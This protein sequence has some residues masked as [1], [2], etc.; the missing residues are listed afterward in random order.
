MADQPAPCATGPVP[1][2][3]VPRRLC[4]RL[5]QLRARVAQASPTTRALL[6]S[7]GAGVVFSL[8]NALLRLLAQQLHPLQAQ[9][10][11]YFF[12]LVVML[13]LVWRAGVLAYRPR[14]I[15]GQFLRG[16]V[17]AAGL[18]LWFTAL[19]RIALADMTAIGFT[20]PLFIMIGAWLFLAE[21]MRW[22]R[23]LATGIGFV[24]ML[25][26][27]APAVVG[28]GVQAG[29]WHLVMLASAPVFAASFLLTKAL[30]RTERTEVIV[31]WQAL[32]VTLFSIP[33]AWPVWQW[34]SA[35][36]WLGFALAGLLGSMGHYAL[37]R[38]YH[39]ADI[40][41]TQTVKFLDLVWAALLGLALL[42]EVPSASTLAGGAIISLATLWLVRRESR[43]V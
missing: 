13:P 7:A 19:P 39:E 17:H 14:R 6:W 18:V 20:V 40:S 5:Q 28:A 27:L 12:S 16:A 32:T 43:A 25:V 33:L 1:R 30:T 42:G 21:P 29:R 31:L 3:P 11:R 26:M 35:W 8:L 9:F 38:S 15:G 41:A 34:P 10:L 2:L 37:T 22:E 4:G 36:Q 24:G 23:W